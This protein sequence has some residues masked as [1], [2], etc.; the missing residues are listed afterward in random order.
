MCI[1]EILT[2]DISSIRCYLNE[3]GILY[4]NL[5]LVKNGSSLSVNFT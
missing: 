3:I 1:H 2:L 5:F 4:Q